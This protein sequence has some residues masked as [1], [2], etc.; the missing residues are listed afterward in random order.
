MPP[1]LVA[2]LLAAHGL[3]HTSYASPAPPPSASG[4]AWPFYLD[5]SWALTPLGLG[6]AAIRAVGLLLIA[7]VVA[8]FAVAAL[9]VLGIVPGSW[10]G[11]AV[12]GA[13]VVSAVLLALFFTPWIVFGFAIDVAILFAVLVSGWR[14]GAAL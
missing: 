9:A 4:P 5:H 2:L 8:G 12:V 1:L 11:P 3:V 10:F 13:S 6:P 14:P 7:A